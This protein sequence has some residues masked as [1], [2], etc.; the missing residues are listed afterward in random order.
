LIEKIFSE[1]QTRDDAFLEI[2]KAMSKIIQ[3]GPYRIVIVYPPLSDGLEITV[4][5]PVKKL[6]LE[7]YEISEE[8]MTILRNKSQ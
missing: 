8:L 7:D 5:K 1:L 2:D 4:V 6:S 3:V